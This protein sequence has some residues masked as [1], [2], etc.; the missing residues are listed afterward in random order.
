M[1]TPAALTAAGAGRLA[2]AS[3]PVLGAGSAAPHVIVLGGGISGL[4]LAY[5][6]KRYRGSRVTVTLLE[7]SARAGGWIRTAEVGGRPFECGPRGVRPIGAGRETMALAEQLGLAE[8][9]LGADEAAKARYLYSGGA[10]RKL[11]SSLLEA[12]RSPLTSWLGAPLLHEWHAPAAAAAN[13]ST[14]SSVGAG[15]A[16]GAGDESVRR[17]VL[18]RFGDARVLETLIDPLIS[19]IYSGD[20]AK[21]SLRSCFA[22]LAQVTNR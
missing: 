7:G 6:L 11:P 16:A 4:S 13:S 22:R 2:A 5:F 18:R 8:L 14:A 10:L 21:L 20:P 3:A 15:A 19:G 9:A 1:S 17:W 12:V